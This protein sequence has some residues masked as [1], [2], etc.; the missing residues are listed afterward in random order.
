MKEYA[1]ETTILNKKRY[2]AHIT[3]RDFDKRLVIETST[4][5]EQALTWPTKRKALEIL[6]KCI[7][8]D[9]EFTVVPMDI[10]E[11]P[12]PKFSKQAESARIK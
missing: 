3:E 2:I 7:V 4:D 12:E 1:L 10:Q 11:Q 8:N 5:P 9:R 6:S